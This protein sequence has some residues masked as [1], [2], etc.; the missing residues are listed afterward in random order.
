MLSNVS[1]KTQRTD[2]LPT[3]PLPS[4]LDASI[5]RARRRLM[6]FLLLMY[7]VA[8]L[9]RTNIAFAKQALQTQVGISPHSYALGAGLFFLSYAVF[10]IPSNLMLHKI[11]AK[12][13]MARIMVSWGLVSVATL[14]VQGP[15]SFYFARLLLGAMEAGFFPGVILYLTYWFPSRVRGQVLGFFYIGAPLAF[16]CGGPVSGLLL[17]MHTGG[18]LRNWQWMFLIEGMLAVAVGIWSYGYLDNDPSE[19]AW[20]A[21]N[22][23]KALTEA[24]GQE[25]QDRHLHTSTEILP[26]LRDSRMLLFTLI[27]LLI[28]TSVYGAVFY[29]PSEVSG[30]LHRSAGWQVGVVSAIPWLCALAAS[31]WLPRFADRTGRHRQ[32]TALTLLVAGC[33]SAAFP[34]LGAGAGICALSV[35]VSGFIAAQP[36]FWTFPT[37]YL[38]GRAAAAGLAFINTIGN[39][40]GFFAPN[41]KFWG[42]S[43]FGSPRAG[44]LLLASLTFAGAILARGLQKSS[45]NRLEL[46]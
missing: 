29:L 4:T 38:S 43:Y 28:Q 20:L 1:R 30:I 21:P 15:R 39:L 33:A 37:N 19:A 36:L 9:D 26:M 23:R 18:L 5:A 10:E 8:F 24:L 46:P 35:A 22:E 40:G 12:P 32:L 42:D 2:L 13:W 6:P 14:F 3:A 45:P 11:G 17:Q 44:I 7:V 27:Y 31:F 34:L 41:I 16:I 25:K